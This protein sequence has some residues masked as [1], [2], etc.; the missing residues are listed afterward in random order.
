MLLA[1][2][3]RSISQLKSC[4][5]FTVCAS[6]CSDFLSS[7]TGRPIGRPLPRTSISVEEIQKNLLEH[8]KAGDAERYQ[9]AQVDEWMV[10]GGCAV[11]IEKTLRQREKY[12]SRVKFSTLQELLERAEKTDFL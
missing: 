6:D 5:H 4:S 11:P 2:G 9:L 7:L 1:N 10:C 3:L 12:F 8:D